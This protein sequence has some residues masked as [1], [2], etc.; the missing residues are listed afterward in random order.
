MDTNTK[1]LFIREE[2][3]DEGML[4]CEDGGLMAY[5]HNGEH[6]LGTYYGRIDWESVKGKY[7]VEDVLNPMFEDN[8][9]SRN[10][11]DHE[12][13]DIILPC[14]LEED[15]DW[16]MCPRQGEFFDNLTVIKEGKL[17]FK[18]LF[19]FLLEGQ[20][21]EQIQNEMNAPVVPAQD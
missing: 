8:G 12:G 7:K 1:Y 5:H 16:M 18:I 6:I 13:H 3:D 17:T 20:V 9:F 11:F 2:G 14:I 4:I 21:K 15:A 19:D 10:L